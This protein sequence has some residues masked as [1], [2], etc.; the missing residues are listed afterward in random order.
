[1]HSAAVDILG[2]VSWAYIH[3]LFNMYV[4]KRELLGLRLGTCSSFAGIVRQ[5]SLKWSY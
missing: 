3:M 4:P 1:M 2:G 5:F